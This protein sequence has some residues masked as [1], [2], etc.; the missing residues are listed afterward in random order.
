MKKGGITPPMPPNSAP[1]IIGRLVE[2]GLTEAAGMGAAPLSWQSIHAWQTVTGIRLAPWEAR[3]IRALS[4]EYLAEG[5]RA[6]TENCPPPWRAEVT[7]RERE[8][9][10]DRLRVVLG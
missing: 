5:R 6:E 9:E 3:L 8:T 4:V 2:I 10:V 7:E 1:H